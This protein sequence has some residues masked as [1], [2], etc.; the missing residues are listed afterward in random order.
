[1]KVY[2]FTKEQ[3]QRIEVA[4]DDPDGDEDLL[5]LKAELEEMVVENIRTLSIEDVIMKDHL[6]NAECA[7]ESLYYIKDAYDRGGKL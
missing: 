6:E 5:D 1:M 4:F 7:I 3:I 2:E